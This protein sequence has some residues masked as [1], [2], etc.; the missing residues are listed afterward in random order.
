MEEWLVGDFYLTIWFFGMVLPSGTMNSCSCSLAWQVLHLKTQTYSWGTGRPP[1]KEGPSF[2]TIFL[3]IMFLWENLHYRTS[4]PNYLAGNGQYQCCGSALDSMRIRIQRSKPMWIRADK[5]KSGWDIKAVLWFI[6]IP[7]QT[8]LLTFL[9]STLCW[10]CIQ[11]RF[12]NRNCNAFRFRQGKTKFVWLFWS[13]FMLLDLDPVPQYG[14][15]FQDRKINADPCGS[16]STTLLDSN[17]FHSNRKNTSIPLW[18][19]FGRDPD[20]RTL[21][22]GFGSCFFFQWFPTKNQVCWRK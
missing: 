21:D 12:Q 19:H 18:W 16:R 17:F 5:S 6:A 1:W 22:Y 20:L 10:I 8:F 4:V 11:I 2:A 9:N 14:P 7:V 13:I 3:R 15:R